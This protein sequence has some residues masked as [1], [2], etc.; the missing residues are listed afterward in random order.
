MLN[1]PYDDSLGDKTIPHA[2]WH[3]LEEHADERGWASL[4][5]DAQATALERVTAK[6]DLITICDRAAAN[7]VSDSADSA[8][9][10]GAR[11]EQTSGAE[12]DR[13]LRVGRA[14]AEG[15]TAPRV[16]VDAVGVV[17]VASEPFEVDPS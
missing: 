10:I 5:E 6:H 7:L 12:R 17:I 11:R 1:E 13:E 15:I 9:R 8:E 14:L 16:E 4:C 3:L 2:L